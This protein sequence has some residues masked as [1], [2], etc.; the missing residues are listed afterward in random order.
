MRVG[1][2]VGPFYASTST[3]RRRSR[4]GSAGQGFG[5]VVALAAVIWP[6][7]IG[8][9]NNGSYRWWMWLIAIPWWILLLLLAVGYVVSKNDKGKPGQGRGQGQ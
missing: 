9:E 3:R 7:I 4:R 5:L 8:Q 6:L 1:M 2:R